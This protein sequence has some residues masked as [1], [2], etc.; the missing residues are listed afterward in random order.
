MKWILIL[1]I[2][3]F[4]SAQVTLTEEESKKIAINVQNLQFE[5]DSLKNIVFAQSDLIFNY[6][7][8]VR[9]D[10]TLT[11][12]LEEKIEI[13]EGDT[14]LL[15]K[16]VKLVKPSWYENKWLYFTSGAIISAAVTYTFNRITN[17][18]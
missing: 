7:E 15:E 16:K 4:C 5:V 6:R 17:I 3:V 10:S 12:Q 11:A 8:I 2:T 18:L 9:T 14:E 13:L 1:L